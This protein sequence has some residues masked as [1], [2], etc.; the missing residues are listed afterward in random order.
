MY[1]ILYIRIV[2]KIQ[3]IKFNDRI[4][5]NLLYLSLLIYV[6]NLTGKIHY[7]TNKF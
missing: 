1:S 6:K 5:I 7:K 4:A 2:K 3:I